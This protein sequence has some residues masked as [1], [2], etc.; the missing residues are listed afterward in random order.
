MTLQRSPTIITVLGIVVHRLCSI[1]ATNF[2]SAGCWSR[3]IKLDVA[4][5]I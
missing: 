3:W 2:L 4:K 5:A 1:A